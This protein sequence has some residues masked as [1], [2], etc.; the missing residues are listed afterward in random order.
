MFPEL[1]QD[2]DH[3]GRETY[4]QLPKGVADDKIAWELP[5]PLYGLS[6]A[7]KDWYKTIRKFSPEECGVG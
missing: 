6:T 7:C 4:V 3:W 1:S 2:L 5:N